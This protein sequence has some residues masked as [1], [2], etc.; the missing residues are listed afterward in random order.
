MFERIKFIALY[1]FVKQFVYTYDFTWKEYFRDFGILEKWVSHI[2][3][4]TCDLCRVQNHLRNSRFIIYV[5]SNYQMY[6]LF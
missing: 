4:H 1:I 2:L 6:K 3:I 5:C